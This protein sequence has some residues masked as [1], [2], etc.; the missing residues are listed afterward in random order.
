MHGESFGKVT[1][2]TDVHF[3]IFN[4]YEKLYIVYADFMMCFLIK[5][6]RLLYL[7]LC[8]FT[9]NGCTSMKNNVKK[10]QCII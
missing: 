9:V 3:Y 8:F 7:F 4:S 5:L 2:F 1:L 6:D 10:W